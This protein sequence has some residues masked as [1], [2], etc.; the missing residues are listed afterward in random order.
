MEGKNI[1]FNLKDDSLPS[2]AG[3]SVHPKSSSVSVFNFKADWDPKSFTNSTSI[4]ALSGLDSVWK[5]RS[6]TNFSESARSSYIDMS[7]STVRS[8]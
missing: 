4:I 1:L 2:Y 7:M 8:L 3:S 6:L 5:Y